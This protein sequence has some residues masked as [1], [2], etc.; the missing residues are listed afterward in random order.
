MHLVTSDGTVVMSDTDRELVGQVLDGRK[1]IIGGS[2]L[3]P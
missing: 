3:L 1:V 2:H